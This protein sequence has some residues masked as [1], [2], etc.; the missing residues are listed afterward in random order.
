MLIRAHEMLIR[1]HEML[2]RAH[3]MLFRAH[4]L[5]IRAHQI[6]KFY[7]GRNQA[8]VQYT[9]SPSNVPVQ[10][11]KHLKQTYFR[12]PGPITQIQ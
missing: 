8:S 11:S 2:F 12:W 4:Q 6:K 5:L 10:K 3:E 9:T 7:A 1:A